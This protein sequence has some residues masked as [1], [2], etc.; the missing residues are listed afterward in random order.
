[1]PHAIYLLT[2]MWALQLV[3][4]LN[5]GSLGSYGI[6]PR[7][8]SGLFGIPLAPWIHHGWWH[9]I[10]NSVPFL[11]LGVLLQSKSTA[12]FW[13]STFF[14]IFIAGLGTWLLGSQGYHVGASGLILGY[15]SFIIADACFQRS[16]R[17]VLIAVISFAIYGGLFFTLFDFR[18]HISWAGHVSGL[19]AGVIVATLWRSKFRGI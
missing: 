5:W 18:P 15:L 11:V 9:L 14:I 12:I 4:T 17:A 10:S 16:I 1:M 6:M 13:Q 3:Q 2:I 8:L 7:D 19:L